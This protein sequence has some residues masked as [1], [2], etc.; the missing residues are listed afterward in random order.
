MAV[1]LDTLLTR[2]IKNMGSGIHP[3]VKETVVEVIK[4]AYKEGIYAQ[5]SMGHRTMEQQAALFGQGRN[6]YVYKGKQYGNPSK[7]K[8][9]NALPGQSMHNFGLAIDYFLVSK[10]GNTALWTVNAQWRRVAQI[11]K[12]LGFAWGGDWKGFVDYPHLDMMGGLTLAQLQAGKKPNLVSK[13]KNSTPVPSVSVSNKYDFDVKKLQQDLIK[14]GYKL[15]KFGAD[16]DYGKETESAVK[17]F[18]KDAKIAV[19]GIVGKMTL[20]AIE[21]KLKELSKPKEPVKSKEELS[22]SQYNE[23]KKEIESLK[24]ALDNKQTIAK[25]NTPDPAHE[26]AWEWL[27]CQKLSDGSNPQSPLTRE[28]LASILKKYDE[29]KGK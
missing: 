29:L 9:T 24:K 15:P 6:S 25:G 26:L 21:K 17:A 16:G 3:V 1:S 22:V 2:S 5:V 8:V 14:L 4:R 12:S 23:L 11:A 18:Q 13:V 28:Q 27:K 10:D 20:Q 19:D 7:P